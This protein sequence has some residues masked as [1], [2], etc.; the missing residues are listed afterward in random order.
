MAR[1]LFLAALACFAIVILT[2][3]AEWFQMF[4]AMGWGR[5]DS[6]GHDL[7]LASAVLGIGL[8]VAGSITF[9]MKRGR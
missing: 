4:P 5:P 8:L 3:V 1:R 6:P 7:D 2:H 9:A